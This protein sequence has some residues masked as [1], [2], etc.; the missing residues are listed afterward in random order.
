LCR[1]EMRSRRQPPGR[2]PQSRYH[3]KS[4]ARNPKSETKADGSS[5]FRIS[6]FGFESGGVGVGA[7]PVHQEGEAAQADQVAGPDDR[8]TDPAAVDV[9]AVEAVQVVDVPGAVLELETA[10]EA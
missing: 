4:E 6:C 1:P 2:P 9:D 10:V 8:A 7:G 5:L 3:R